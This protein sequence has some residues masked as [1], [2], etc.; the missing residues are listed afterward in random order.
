MTDYNALI[1]ASFIVYLLFDSIMTQRALRKLAER[2]SRLE[3][4]VK[5]EECVRE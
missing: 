4:M 2:V 5:R 3:S 1:A